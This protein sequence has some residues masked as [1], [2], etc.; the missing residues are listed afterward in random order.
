MHYK[1]SNIPSKKTKSRVKRI[2]KLL[3]SLTSAPETSVNVFLK[4]YSNTYISQDT[5]PENC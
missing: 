4:I 2:N 5:I 1:E 3:V